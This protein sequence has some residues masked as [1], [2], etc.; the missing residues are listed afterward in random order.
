MNFLMS[1]VVLIVVV[2]GLGF[3]LGKQ[4]FEGPG[5]LESTDTV[6]IRPN[7]GVAEIVHVPIKAVIFEDW[8]MVRRPMIDMVMAA[9]SLH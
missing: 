2:G 5:P 3:F 6:L 8:G 9:Y 4:A 7:T 1:L